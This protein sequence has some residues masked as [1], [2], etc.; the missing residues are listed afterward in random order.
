MHESNTDVDLSHAHLETSDTD[1]LAVK[2]DY[3]GPY[4]NGEYSG[5]LQEIPT[6]SNLNNAVKVQISDHLVQVPDEGFQE[7]SLPVDAVEVPV[8]MVRNPIVTNLTGTQTLT[9]VASH[10][11]SNVILPENLEHNLA[12]DN[13]AVALSG[14]SG[15]EG[16]GEM[17]TIMQIPVQVKT[18][19]TVPTAEECTYLIS[20]TVQGEGQDTEEGSKLENETEICGDVEALLKN[21]ELN[22]PQRAS[23]PKHNDDFPGDTTI[24]AGNI[25]YNMPVQISGGGGATSKTCEEVKSPTVQTGGEVS[26]FKAP[27]EKSSNSRCEQ[28]TS[29]TVQTA[30]ELSGGNSS[31]KT[32]DKMNATVSGGESSKSCEQLT[33]PTVQTAAE[34]SGGK[35]LKRC[36]QLTSPTFQTAAEVTGGESSKKTYDEMK[37]PVFQAP[38]EKSSKRYEQLTSPQLKKAAEVSGGESSKKTY[39]EMRPPRIDVKSS[40][41]NQN[42]SK[43]K[44]LKEKEIMRN[45]DLHEEGTQEKTHN[46]TYCRNWIQDAN[47]AYPPSEKP[48]GQSDSSTSDGSVSLTDSQLNVTSVSRNKPEYRVKSKAQVKSQVRKTQEDGR[49]MYVS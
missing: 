17:K 22:E 40:K 42:A 47:P 49:D 12:S 41:I 7:I 8:Q 11:V 28:L 24:L 27:V 46:T 26:V 31:K 21:I 23:T 34:V 48:F 18:N 5:V 1:D 39:D 10:I 30:A 45:F 20:L 6:N 37:A 35:P 29:P 16:I 4:S 44:I 25:D 3:V 33:L 13:F 43:R 9:N 36:E 32:D 38:V 14:T 15:I 2:T 19:S